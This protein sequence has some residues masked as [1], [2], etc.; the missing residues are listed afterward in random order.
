MPTPERQQ[1]V[2]VA[3]PSTSR[4]SRRPVLLATAFV[5][6]VCL[7]LLALETWRIFAARTVQ[8]TESQT[9][10]TN[11]AKSLAEH[12]GSTFVQADILLSGLAERLEADGTDAK[13][14]ERIHRLL[15]TQIRSLPQLDR[16][17]VLNARGIKISSDQSVTDPGVDYSDRDY[18]R[19]HAKQTDGASYLGPPIVD[20]T[21]NEWIITIS[22]RFNDANGV[23]AGVVLASINLSYFSD[24]YRRFD[25]GRDGTIVLMMS[26]GTILMRR[27]F[28][29]NLIG[30]SLANGV[31]FKQHMA[32]DDSGTANIKSSID[33]IERLTSFQKVGIFP[34][35][36][37]VS[38]SNDYV[39]GDWVKDSLIH[40][41]A[42]IALLAIL[43]WIGLR[44]I[45]QISRRHQDQV[46]LLRSQE[47]LRALNI[48]LD[49]LAREDGLTGLSN[50]REFD[51]VL[52]EEVMRLDR[53]GGQLALIMLD[54]DR[55]K[56]YN[57]YFG[58]VKGDECIKK[59]AA[60]L[61]LS[62]T[63]PGDTTARYGGEE[64][65]LLLPSTDTEGALVVAK[66]IRSLIHGIALP[67]PR[68]P[69]HIVT[70][71]FGISVLSAGERDITPELLIERADKALYAAKEIGRDTI[72]I[73]QHVARTR[74]WVEA[75]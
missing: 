63:R 43:A 28:V 47:E 11:L 18:F 66:K 35:Y 56:A 6:T 67:H 17:S 1:P 24:Y 73:F 46:L 7:S 42:A 64:F 70:A 16:I 34:A 60:Q 52:S 59:V 54:I 9:A 61:K 51:R 33:G 5:L 41:S 29:E 23:F 40:A 14:I 71:S 12:A 68:G 15:Q 21:T 30:K 62:V 19:H 13:A 25:I 74:T 22:R 4:W 20:R 69:K 31:L 39:L 45:N 48:R 10:A 2:A 44:L 50:R 32:F 72:R 8:I 36:A 53:S 38:L 3:T 27:P 49:G 65:V 57:D 26:N 55:F 58:H 75:A 37:I